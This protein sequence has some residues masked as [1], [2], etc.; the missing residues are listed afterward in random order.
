MSSAP[1]IASQLRR[2]LEETRARL[3]EAE[4]TLNAIRNGEV[5]GLLVA[6]P[7]G[8]QIFTLHGSQEPYRLLIEQMSEGALTLSSEGVILYANQ[9]FAGLLQMPLEQVIGSEFLSFVNP[10]EQ[11]VLTGLIAAACRGNSRGMV[12]VRTAAGTFIPLGLGLSRLQLPPD[13]LLCVVATD[14]TEQ[15][16]KD[17]ALRRF[18]AELEQR[19]AERTADL[20]RSRLAALN[21]MEEAVEARKTA[22]AANRELTQEIAERKRADEALRRSEERHRIVTD[23]MLHGLVHQRGDGTIIAM[24]PAAERI[25]G[26][27][28]AEFLGS[29]SVQEEHRTVHE[30]GSRFPGMEHPA[31]VALRTGQPVRSVVMGVWNPQRE[32]RRWIEIDAVPVFAP[33]QALPTEVYT[34]FADISERKQAE[35]DLRDLNQQ[36]EQRVAERTQKLA[37][38]EANLRAFFDTIDYFCFILDQQ[39][40]ILRVN[41]TVVARLGYAEEELTGMPVVQLHPPERRNEASGIVTAMLE[42]T[43]SSCPVPL[44]A[45]DG[46]L[47]PVETRVVPGTWQGQPALFGVSK[48]I[49]ELRRSEEKF[50]TIFHL[51]P[52]A[53]ALTSLPD[54]RFVEVNAAF[55]LVTGYEPTE[56]IGSTPQEL[57]LFANPAQGAEL[58]R[59]MTE[60]ESFEHQEWCL[61]TKAGSLR[62]GLFSGDRVH[63]QTG[64]LWLTVMDDITER[65]RI[66]EELRQ[67]KEA[68]DAANRAKSRFRANMSHEIRTPMN[69]IL[70][71]AQLLERD[72]ALPE[73][74]RQQVATINRSGAHLLRLIND[75]L[76]MSKIEAGRMPLV[77]VEFDLR[78]LVHELEAMFLLRAEEKRLGF[79]THCAPEVPIYL[80]SDPGKIRQVLLN[81]LGNAFKFT[82]RGGVQL[83]LT[84]EG[85]AATAVAAGQASTRICIEVTDTGV[86]IA[87][88]EMDRLFEAFEQASSGQRQGTGTGL[89]LAISRQL[90]RMLGGDVTLSSQVGVGSTFR[91]SFVATVVDTATSAGAMPTASCRIVRLKPRDPPPVVLVVDDTESNRMLLRNLLEPV[92]F[93]VHEAADGA[94]AVVGCATE[95]PSLVLMDRRMPGLDG[96]AAI[97]AIRKGPAGGSIRILLISATVLD[98]SDQDWKSAG[99]DG[100]ISKPFQNEDLLALIGTLLEVEYL[101]AEPVASA[102]PKPLSAPQTAAPIPDGLRTRILEATEA[103]DIDRLRELIA[104][105]VSPLDA[106]LGQTLARLALDYDYEAIVQALQ[107]PESSINDPHDPMPG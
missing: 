80:R 45:R 39:G 97:R 46:T 24:N 25:L 16:R 59:L 55:T 88:E 37:E 81:L 99:A 48:D 56:A 8:E 6:G 76:D 58:V 33:G 95:P 57:G 73:K 69:A 70:G 75:I 15:H 17:E 38:S 51:N 26:R 63:L 66:A 92:G 77:L 91:F 102:T 11:P 5:D 29:S 23:T 41:Q 1:D 2:E 64:S 62:H 18:Q 89:G 27:P 68:A 103:A 32:E 85:A 67:A 74:Q 31:M 101:E 54:A 12:S 42:G 84:S 30:D 21:L 50:S 49:S 13:T 52:L 9:T 3:A 104:H 90:A 98:T 60:Q 43:R 36:L 4:E 87:A 71:F 44:Q 28:A 107:Q 105:E 14:L 35:Q 20:A 72:P 93:V 86:G 96:L 83:R 47:V 82:A 79:E 100:F 40:N 65:Q 19:V 34:V 7:E 94:E 106:G 78:M 61:R 53:M 10:A 22:E